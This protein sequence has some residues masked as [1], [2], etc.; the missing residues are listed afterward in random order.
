MTMLT[1]TPDGAVVVR[2]ADAETIGHPA[3]IFSR[4]LLDA[5]DTR[6]GHLGVGWT[7]LAEGVD[8]A[9][10]HHHAHRS[11]LFYVIEGEIEVLAGDQVLRAAKGDVVLVPPGMAHAFGAVPGVAAEVLIVLAPAIDRFEYFRTLERIALGKAPAD[12]LLGEQERYDTWFLES[13]PWRAAR[14]S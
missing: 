10:P 12:A 7:T 5:S 4:L 14:S 3:F 6:D 11:E 8:G 9:R 13:E 1:P 2:G